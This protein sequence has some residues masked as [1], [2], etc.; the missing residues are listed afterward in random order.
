MQ[1]VDEGYGRLVEVYVAQAL[2]EG[3]R[4]GDN[5]ELWE[6]NKPTSSDRRILITQ[7]T[8]R[9][10][11]KIDSDIK[12]RTRLFEKTGLA[13]T[14]SSTLKVP[15]KTRTRPSFM[16]VD[17]TPEPQGD[18]TLTRR[19]VLPISPSPADEEHPLGSSDED[20][21]DDEGDEVGSEGE[22]LRRDVDD[23]AV[24]DIDEELADDEVPLPLQIPGGKSLVSSAP[25]SLTA[26]LVKQSILLKLGVGW[27]KGIITRQAQAR[28]R[29]L[30]STTSGFSSIATA[31]RAA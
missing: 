15:R 2:D 29:H 10:V 30:Y 23:M 1:P 12:N 6:S 21:G 31:A 11:R 20:E 5:V 7:W 24:L 28:T 22:R 8:S 26:A 9:A 13:T 27:L 14:T 25:A 19:A 3:L 18:M 17:T 16:D 4:N